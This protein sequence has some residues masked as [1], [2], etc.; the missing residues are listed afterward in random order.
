[1]I[2]LFDR[3]TARCPSASQEFMT[4]CEFRV[5]GEVTLRRTGKK[6]LGPKLR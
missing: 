6:V 2:E 5:K 3:K 1:V 4:A